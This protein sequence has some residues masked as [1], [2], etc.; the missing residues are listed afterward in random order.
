MASHSLPVWK[1]L[2]IGKFSS[3]EAELESAIGVCR[4]EGALAKS[5]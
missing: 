4:L 5:L 2:V 1:G 3:S